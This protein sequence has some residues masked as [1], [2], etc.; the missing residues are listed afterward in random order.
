M[1]FSMLTGTATGVV[2]Q[3]LAVLTAIAGWFI[4]TIPSLFPLFYSPETGLTIV[5][6]LSVCGLGVGVI[7]LLINKVSD[8]FHWRG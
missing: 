2:G 1:M 4:E 5:G 6:V 7:L 3:V 8:F